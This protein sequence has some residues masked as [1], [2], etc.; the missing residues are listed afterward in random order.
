V[1]LALPH[2]ESAAVAAAVPDTVKI[3]DLAAD[4]RDDPR[5]TYGIPELPGRRA[6]IAGSDRVSA[7]GCY[8]T[9]VILGLAPLIAAG[10][11][12]PSDVVVVAA[13]GTSGAGRSPRQHLL[14]T[15][16]IGSM[17]VYKV[18]A[19]QHVPEI[20]RATGAVSVSMT[21]MLAPMPRGILATT[22]A[23]MATVGNHRGELTDCLASAYSDEPFVHLLPSGD[24]P[25][26]GATF[27]TNACLL[28][29]TADIDSGRAIV[30]SAL[31]N[32]GKGAAGQALQC[33]NLMLGLPETAGLTIDGV[34]P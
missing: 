27:G 28:Q 5:W 22:T 34:A 18:G 17:S 1:F 11:V 23:R 20:K 13:S 29:A 21:P 3:V 8:A 6:A 24:W 2:G 15:E 10:I 32:L 30:V 4:H 12:E 25:V 33:A 19:H 14:A 26:T 7:A 16:V 9:A 31:D